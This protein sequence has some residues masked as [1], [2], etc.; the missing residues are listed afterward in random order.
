MQCLYLEHPVDLQHPS[1][2]TPQFQHASPSHSPNIPSIPTISLHLKHSH[3]I[4]HSLSFSLSLSLSPTSSSFL[5]VFPNSEMTASVW[6]CYHSLPSSLLCSTT[7]PCPAFPL[8]THSQYLL[9]FK[10]HH[11]SQNMSQKQFLNLKYFTEKVCI[12]SNI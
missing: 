9:K 5:P 11:K 1:A 2:L 10:F 4:P 12:L 3:S 8:V 6:G 7:L